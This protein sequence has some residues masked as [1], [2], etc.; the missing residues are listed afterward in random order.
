MSVCW[1]VSLA[2]P[3]LDAGVPLDAL[4]EVNSPEMLALRQKRMPRAWTQLA[5]LEYFSNFLLETRKSWQLEHSPG[6]VEN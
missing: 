2:P 3:L 6:R 4:D 5:T 1:D